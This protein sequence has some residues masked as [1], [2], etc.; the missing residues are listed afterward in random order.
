[1]REQDIVVDMT[2][3]D[4]DDATGQINEEAEEEPLNAGAGAE[5]DDEKEPLPPVKKDKRDK[6]KEKVD[7]RP[8][9]EDPRFR[10]A[11]NWDA[12]D[13]RIAELNKKKDKV[14]AAKA[15][16]ESLTQ[17]DR[18][19]EQRIQELG[20]EK[21]DIE[22][23]DAAKNKYL[24]TRVAVGPAP[25]VPKT[26]PAHKGPDTLPSTADSVADVLSKG[27]DA[28]DYVESSEA[29]EEE[30]ERLE[31]RVFESN[32]AKLLESYMPELPKNLKTD[33]ET[34]P[35]EWKDKTKRAN[36]YINDYA[37][38]VGTWLVAAFKHP[39]SV[40][41]QFNGADMGEP[42]FNLRTS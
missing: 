42:L 20:G 9:D 41:E 11:P 36:A 35:E 33:A 19:L 22:Q 14:E 10:P 23:P 40:A 8:E 32:L 27:F 26:D 39:D 16:D 4:D 37:E 2:D 30:R 17:E 28:D 3:A 18:K 21:A 31:S 29:P 12:H 24:K 7:D 1:M 5:S 34:S 13:A 6:G 38:Q 15:A 25:A